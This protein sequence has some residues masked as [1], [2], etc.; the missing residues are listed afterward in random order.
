MP[1]RGRHA[2]RFQPCQEQQRGGSRV[3]AKKKREIWHVLDADRRLKRWPSRHELRVAALVY[4]ASKFDGDRKYSEI[5]VNMLL[6]RW[7]AFDDPALLRRELF[8]RGYIERTRDGREYW[9]V[10]TVH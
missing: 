8:D 1:C 10:A 4:L 3:M 9:K 6:R 5:A 2:F 7:S